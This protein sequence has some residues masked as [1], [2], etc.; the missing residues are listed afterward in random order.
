MKY[1]T[2][3][4]F[5]IENAATIAKALAKG[6]S[7]E[8]SM[9]ML[10]VMENEFANDEDLDYTE[11]YDIGTAVGRPEGI[12]CAVR[13]FTDESVFRETIDVLNNGYTPST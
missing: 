9:R 1:D 11:V 4:P 6:A 12:I 2:D 5:T 10:E 3:M 7:I 8:A 13:I